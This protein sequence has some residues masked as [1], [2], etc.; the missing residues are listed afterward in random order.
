VLSSESTAARMSRNA[1]ATLFGT[2]LYSLDEM[3]EKVDAVSVD[4]VTSLAGELYAAESLSAACI[5]REEDRFRTAVAPVSA[6]L[7]AA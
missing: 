6:S 3:L 4:D 1:R 7:V 5:G 2:P